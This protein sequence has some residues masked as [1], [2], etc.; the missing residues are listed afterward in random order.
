VSHKLRIPCSAVHN[1]EQRWLKLKAYKLQLLQ[2]V[3]E[4]HF[5]DTI[6][7][8]ISNNNNYLNRASFN[9]QA[10]FLASGKAN[11]YNC[12]ILGSQNPPNVKEAERDSLKLNTWRELTNAGAIRS[13]FFH[14]KTVTGALHLD[15]LENYVVPQ[16]PDE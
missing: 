10:T 7:S 2:K 5:T 13:F 16:V 6:H 15:M 3:Q 14:K 8:R 9:E 12:H 1:V 11:C 4:N